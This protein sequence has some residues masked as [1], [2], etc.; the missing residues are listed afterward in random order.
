MLKNNYHTQMR[1]CNHAD[2]MVIDYVNKAIVLGFSELGMSDH[3]PVLK[4]FMSEK[5][6]E[7]NWGYDTMRLDEVDDYLNLYTS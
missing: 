2:G 5:E 4:G 3:A 6:Y 1:Y 7:D